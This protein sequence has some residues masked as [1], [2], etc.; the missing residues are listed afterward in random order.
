M[1]KPVSSEDPDLQ[2]VALKEL[3]NDLP[4]A[5]RRRKAR[6]LGER[7]RI[8]DL[9]DRAA[10]KGVCY[11]EAARVCGCS[12]RDLN[13]WRKQRLEMLR[14]IDALRAGLERLKS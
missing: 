12:I 6:D 2:R 8:L 7:C 3:W 4:A 11:D 13:E 1:S 5:L 10:S 9:I 14:K